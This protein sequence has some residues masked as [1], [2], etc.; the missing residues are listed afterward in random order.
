MSENSNEHIDIS[1][2]TDQ[3][4]RNEKTGDVKGKPLKYE[5]RHR[6][7]RLLDERVNNKHKY[8]EIAHIMQVH[9][10]TVHNYDKARELQQLPKQPGKNTN[11]EIC[12][13]TVGAPLP[14]KQGGFR[15]SRMNDEQ[16]DTC[17]R[18]A[19]ENPRDTVSQLKSKMNY[20]YP[21]L[22][23]SDS[24]IWR[25]LSAANISY[26]RA[27]M[28]DP[29]GEGEIATNAKNAEFKS[30]LA[31]QK[32][33]HGMLHPINLFFMD[34]TIVS[35]NDVAKRGWG[36]KEDVPEFA[37]SK[38][39]TM[40]I[41][42][43]AG[44]GLV[45]P[46]TGTE[47]NIRTVPPVLDITTP[48][49]SHMKFNP[50]EK[51]W[52][53]VSQPEF[54]LFWWIR[55]P[56]RAMTSISRFLS[57]DDIL[58]SSF[59]LFDPS[60]IDEKCDMQDLNE[61]N[62]S[63]TCGF[64]RP[65]LT[66]PRS[67]FFKR[68]EGIEVVSAGSAGGSFNVNIK[69]RDGDTYIIMANKCE[70]QGDAVTAKEL[71]EKQEYFRQHTGIDQYFVLLV[72][73]DQEEY[74][75]IRNRYVADTDMLHA[76][77]LEVFLSTEVDDKNIYDLL[78]LNGI[79]YRQVDKT[80]GS[81]I[82]DEYK[83]HIYVSVSDAQQLYNE[84]KVLVK[85][86]LRIDT[87]VAAST[88]IPRMYYSDNGRNFKGGRINSER[89]DRALFFQYMTHAVNYYNNIFGVSDELRVAF[90]SAP[91]H[92]KVDID[93]NH[94]S[95]VHKFFKQKLGI[96]A[97]IFLP[98][99]APDFNP[100]ELLFSYIKGQLRLKQRSFT[101]VATVSKMV[102]LID[103]AFSNVTK[104]MVEGWV[105]YGC[106]KD[107][108]DKTTSLDPKRCG[109]QE[110][111]TVEPIDF[112]QFALKDWQN[113]VAHKYPDLHVEGVL[114]SGR[115]NDD[116][117]NKILHNDGW[118][119]RLNNLLHD[120]EQ[121][122]YFKKWQNAVFL[123]HSS[124]LKRIKEMLLE[125]G[126]LF[127]TFSN[128]LRCTYV[129]TKNNGSDR[130]ASVNEITKQGT[131]YVLR[132][133]NGEF[134]KQ[135][136]VFHLDNNYFKNGCLMLFENALI[137]EV[138]DLW[139]ILQNRESN[140]SFP[141]MAS[142]I[143]RNTSSTSLLHAVY[144]I[145]SYMNHEAG[146][147]L[148]VSPCQQT[149][150]HVIHN[151]LLSSDNPF[152]NP[153]LSILEGYEPLVSKDDYVKIENDKITELNEISIDVQ[154]SQWA[155]QQIPR[156]KVTKA[157]SRYFEIKPDSSIKLSNPRRLQMSD[158]IWQLIPN[159][160]TELHKTPYKISLP[161]TVTNSEAHA[162]KV[163]YVLDVCLLLSKII[164]HETSII[165]EV[166]R[167]LSASLYTELQKS[168]VN[169]IKIETL[170]DEAIRKLSR[171]CTTCNKSKFKRFPV[172]DIHKIRERH[173]QEVEMKRKAFYKKKKGERRWPGYPNEMP[174]ETH[175]ERG[176]G[177]DYDITTITTYDRKTE[178]RANNI[179]ERIDKITLNDDSWTVDCVIN[180][181]AKQINQSNT[182]DW[183]LYFGPFSQENNIRFEKAKQRKKEA[184]NKARKYLNR[185]NKIPQTVSP[186]NQSL[187]LKKADTSNDES[188]YYDSKKK[189][190]YPPLG[191]SKN[192]DTFYYDS[193]KKRLYP[194]LRKSKNETNDY[195]DKTGR[196]RVKVLPN[197][198][199]FT[200]S[201]FNNA[202]LLVG[203]K[204]DVT[205]LDNKGFVLKDVLPYPWKAFG[206][207]IY[208]WRSSNMCYMTEDDF[209]KHLGLSNVK[210][211]SKTHGVQECFV[212]GSGTRNNL[213]RYYIVVDTNVV[214][215]KD[216]ITDI[217][218]R[219]KLFG[220]NELPL[221]D[222]LLEK[223]D[224]DE[225]TKNITTY[226]Q[227]IRQRAG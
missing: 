58:D 170:C 192:D 63:I 132:S 218:N 21:T 86:A 147:M 67:V 179:I 78:W 9:P 18:L 57:V 37:K 181:E 77:S 76:K 100:V 6:I 68:I 129:I 183:K 117:M 155:Q 12:N 112:V 227:Q 95:Y 186:S 29:L 128:G 3:R 180:G 97:A 184:D 62:L 153:V 107:P 166:N 208:K 140:S 195:I 87:T 194:P 113:T 204:D 11:N 55:P 203:D 26:M 46:R 209:K 79:E 142:F 19:V 65:I 133:D 182:A 144:V 211:T 59:T 193:E 201:V 20:V 5:V 2:G 176:N 165:E 114:T 94:Y 27:K 135:T 175:K 16:K 223:N 152:S 61:P 23:V 1:T 70:R 221:K 205:T 35:L 119:T 28:K 222:L 125:D 137:P 141:A 115:L 72:Q 172:F 154:L 53:G 66:Q 207:N 167:D 43:Y 41:S 54:A 127:V 168:N 161:E 4:I 38:G 213:Q 108:N 104:T 101:G 49:G 185:T 226:L 220:N 106:Y 120:K 99:K 164:L 191:K 93:S 131:E 40:T 124:E 198:S 36:S 162:M 56:T 136:T 171:T 47:P 98:V 111:P 83:R 122:V 212:E 44:L 52:D 75:S 126:M 51:I 8:K 134:F 42:L 214:L 206:I 85:I 15:W 190:L 71:I 80:D 224:A 17:V 24:T 225:H 197:N 158:R 210:C 96:R 30:F 188:F 151:I 139:N 145:R 73:N 10:K 196:T 178:K 189:R 88:V 89:G 177:P 159:V 50:V 156:S 48:R 25:T 69:W 14:G 110:H 146:P 7:M 39:K 91:Q 130:N 163:K 187:F 64:F 216:R 150:D 118:D 109:I 34:E 105:Q 123:R 215:T 173:T 148:S 217:H 121:S 31:E 13:Y 174:P 33:E 103:E 90:D 200:I 22:T 199:N 219:M 138:R 32:K 81:L 116:I 82:K 160:V 157:N 169:W 143:E 60:Q 92:G 149:L 84:L 102:E 202:H 45:K 74:Y